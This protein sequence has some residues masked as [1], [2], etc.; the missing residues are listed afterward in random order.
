MLKSDLHVLG[1]G[2]ADDVVVIAIG[3]ELQALLKEGIA[4]FHLA[5]GHHT[6]A[7]VDLDAFQHFVDDAAGIV[8]GFQEGRLEAQLEGT[9]GIDSSRK[10]LT[11]ILLTT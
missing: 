1:Q 10:I 8:G 7:A 11:N 2:L 3:T 5:Q 9:E 4:H 6:P